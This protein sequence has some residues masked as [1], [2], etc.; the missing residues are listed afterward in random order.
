MIGI[1]QELSEIE[2]I[3]TLNKGDSSSLTEVGPF[4]SEKDALSWLSFLK[5]RIGDIREIYS[6]P[7]PHKGSVWYGFTFEQASSLHK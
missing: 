1:T 7:D 2:S 5:S 6:K 3:I 4:L